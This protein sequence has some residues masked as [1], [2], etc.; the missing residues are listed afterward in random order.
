MDTAADHI[1]Q[2]VTGL[3]T[4]RWMSEEHVL[5]ADMVR[6][7]LAAELVPNANEWAKQGVVPKEFWRQAGELGLLGTSI[8]EEYG[9]SGGDYGYDLVVL[10]EQGRAGD[11][12]WGISVHSIVIHYVLNCGTDQQKQRWLPKLSSGKLIGAIAMSEPGTGSDLQG[13]RTTATLDGDEYV[14]N[15]SKT[16]V[17]N[18][19]NANLVVVATKTDPALGAKGISLVVVETDRVEGF[20]RGPTLEKIG[21][22]A[23]DTSE[24][25]FDN[26]RL[27]AA[28][29]LGGAAGQG[30]YQ[31]MQ[32]LGFERL[33]ISV[34]ALGSSELALSETIRYAGERKAFG[35]SL[36]EFQNTR[37]K[38][39]ECKT[40][41]E[42][43]RAFI[44]DAIEN[45]LAGRL[46]P[47][48]ASMVKLFS[49]ET[50]GEIVDDCLQLHGGY[51]YMLDYPIA[52]LYVDARVQRIYGG[53]SEIQK[54]IIARSLSAD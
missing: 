3:S 13:V 47:A 41:L 24:L 36:M 17:T 20:R 22:K 26:L 30:F 15:G 5:L 52:R 19:Q 21:M 8:P 33:A 38:L 6:K 42:A 2:S 39:A 16:F 49:A 9:G 35:K 31:L 44:N 45:L 14:I 40:K 4:P 25:F 32:E 54:E 10:H 50:Q 48:T 29:L 51:G 18:G 12:G 34:T 28:N 27:P 23:Q 1:A 53:T 46:E 43:M 7:F 37:F 11:V